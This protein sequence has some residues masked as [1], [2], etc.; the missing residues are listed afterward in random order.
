MTQ[1]IVIVGAGIIGA[2]I[3]LHLSEG[4]ADVTVLDAAA[5]ASGASG[6]SFGWINA[7]FAE[8]PAYFRLRRAAIDAFR[9]VADRIGASAPVR[10]HGSL[11]WEDSGADFDAHFA[12]MKAFGY[13]AELVDAAGFRA[14][15]PDVADPPDQCIRTTVEG[16]ADGEAMTRALLAAAAAWGATVVAGCKVTGFVV[17]GDQVTGVTTNFGDIAADCVVVATGVACGELLATVGERLPMDNKT[18]V[19]VH[20]APVA[21]IVRHVIMSP[22]I[23]FRQENDGRVIMGEVFSGGGL[24]EALGESP[25]DF[26]AKMLERL[27][28]R[29]PSVPDLKVAAI[30]TGQ[31]PVP[32]DGFPVVGAARGVQGLYMASMHSGITLG[33]LVGKLAAQDILHGQRDDMLAPYGPERFN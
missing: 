12:E 9:D 7:N 30:M 4:G 10:W 28:A 3:A 19:I 22:D 2:S 18:G 33:P 14:L 20:T 17:Q 21:P 26:A 25:A 13:E 8:T 6:K 32:V 24:D 31:R 11:W 5:P 15:E 27:R 29:L 1:K 16:A 23:H